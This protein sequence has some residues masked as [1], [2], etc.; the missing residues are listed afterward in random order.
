M[1]RKSAFAKSKPVTL[2]INS[3]FSQA[4][5]KKKDNFVNEEKENTSLFM[6]KMFKAGLSSDNQMIS[7]YK[8]ETKRLK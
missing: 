7:D 8:K 4:Q 6:K 5:T 1:K 2:D 3:E